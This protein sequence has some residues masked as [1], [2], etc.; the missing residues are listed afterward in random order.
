MSEAK[1]NPENAKRATTMIDM[2]LEIRRLRTLYAAAWSECE[3]S[4]RTYCDS[5]SSFNMRTER[6]AHDAARREA[7][8][9]K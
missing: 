8:E 5:D 1:F 3:A 7:G 4:R 2:E 9:D 6:A